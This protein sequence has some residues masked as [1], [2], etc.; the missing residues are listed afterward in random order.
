MSEPEEDECIT[1]LRGLDHS[2][3]PL[4]EERDAASKLLTALP[5]RITMRPGLGESDWRVWELV[6]VIFLRQGRLHE[7]AALL[8]ALY[9]NMLEAQR[10]LSSRLHKGMPLVRLSDCFTALGFPLHAKRYMMLTLVEDALRGQGFISPSTTGTYFRLVW[11]YGMSHEDLAKYAKD[12]NDLALKEPDLAGFPEALLQSM[13]QHWLSELPS[14]GERSLFRINKDYAKHLLSGLGDTTGKTLERL[15]EY[16]MSCLPGCRVRRRVRSVATDY[17]LVCA[18][19][20]PGFDFRSEFGSYFVCECKDWSGSADFTTVA[21]LCRVLDSTKARFGVLFSKNGVSDSGER[22]RLKVFHD[23]GIVVV[24]LDLDD[25]QR[26]AEG[27]NMVTL[28]RDR[29]EQVRLDLRR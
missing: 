16:F 2:I 21:K 10:L 23:R 4:L 22:E 25:L 5:I 6:S 14:S 20:G 8:W 18:V 9:E 15:A 11:G 19:E 29:Y 26:V 12:A 1:E 13:D 17:D 7:A 27:A 28:L 3:L 24:V